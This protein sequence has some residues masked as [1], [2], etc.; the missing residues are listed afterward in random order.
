[1]EDT[2]SADPTS[3]SIKPRARF[4]LAW[5]IL[6]AGALIFGVGAALLVLSYTQQQSTIGHW[7]LRL[8]CEWANRRR[9]SA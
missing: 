6:L 8:C 7:A 2:Q 3:S 9:S 4:P 1:M 5:V